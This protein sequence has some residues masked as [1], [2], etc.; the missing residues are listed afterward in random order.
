MAPELIQ[1]PVLQIPGRDE[2]PALVPNSIPQESSLSPDEGS[3]PIP[4]RPYIPASGQAS[5]AMFEN[6]KNVIINGG[7]FNQT[8]SM[9]TPRSSRSGIILQRQVFT[10]LSNNISGIYQQ[11]MASVRAGT[12]L[13]I[14]EG[15]SN[16]EDP[17]QD[18][19]V[20]IGD[21]GT[22]TRSGSFSFLFNICLPADHPV[23]RNL[24]PEGFKPIYPAVDPCD[25]REIHEFMPMDYISTDCIRKLANDSDDPT[26]NAPLISFQVQE[27]DG[28]VVVMPEGAISQDLE[29]V[30][31]FRSYAASNLENWYRY[32]NVTRGRE[33]ENGEL[34]LVIGC[35]KTTSWAIAAVPRQNQVTTL[36][37][38]TA[39]D[40]QRY[41]FLP[42]SWDSSGFGQARAG[43]TKYRNPKDA[44]NTPPKLDQCLFVRTMNL[45]LGINEWSNSSDSMPAS[46]SSPSSAL[47]PASYLCSSS[48]GPQRS[49]TLSGLPRTDT[50][51]N[52]RLL[53][54]VRVTVETPGGPP[55]PFKHASDL[56]HNIML[57]MYPE[58]KMAIT[59]DDE[60]L[61]YFKL[62]NPND[63][64]STLSHDQIV[65]RLKALYEIKYDGVV[66]YLEKKQNPTPPSGDDAAKHDSDSEDQT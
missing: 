16:L 35:D 23:N 18:Q 26:S 9:P 38:R 1:F 50:I 60:F 19:G 8:I 52:P 33:I 65:D 58:A 30:S 10:A 20:S 56:L 32:A 47:E 36:H 45:K 17:Y 48:S 14:P 43:P 39:R 13:W 37:L 63:P 62:L 7:Q 53:H 27:G 21:V 3:L 51:L 6:A 42:Y 41:P 57:S 12:A 61:H 2:L 64:T 34:R 22:V 11:H 49:F 66:V 29:N 40:N 15:H 44:D 28:S 5:I 59:E 46:T 55:T 54:N 24:V 25:I 4:Q 31:K